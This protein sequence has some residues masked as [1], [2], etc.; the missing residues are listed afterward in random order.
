MLK[1]LLSKLFGHRTHQSAEAPSTHPDPKGSEPG[2]EEYLEGEP[3]LDPPFGK[4]NFGDLKKLDPIARESLGQERGKPI[5]RYYIEQFMHQNKGDVKGTVLEMEDNT[6]TVRFGQGAVEKSEVLHLDPNNPQATFIGDLTKGDFLPSNHFDCVICT[7]TL[8][9]IYDFRAAIKTI[10]RILKPGGV[11][12]VSF[13]NLSPIV[14]YEGVSWKDC[15]RFTKYSARRVFE[16]FFPQ[17]NITVTSHGNVY[18]AIAQFH[19]LGR[20]ELSKEELDYHDPAFQV[21]ITLRAKK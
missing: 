2:E 7:Q 14:D 5:E 3:G 10:H 4:V 17:D 8:F 20:G 15:W 11:V 16:E 19:G 12:L 1:K 21:V 9:V 18:V 13:P 6:Y